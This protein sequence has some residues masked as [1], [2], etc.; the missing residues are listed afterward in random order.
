MLSSAQRCQPRGDT[1]EWRLRRERGT[2]RTRDRGVSEKQEGMSQTAR[3]DRAPGRVEHVAR[4]I[5]DGIC[6]AVV[7]RHPCSGAKKTQPT[8]R[9]E[10]LCRNISFELIYG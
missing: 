10:I 8:G 3:S 1:V 7:P 9:G 2:A 4:A 6:R 5:P